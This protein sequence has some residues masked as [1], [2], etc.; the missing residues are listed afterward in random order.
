MN[1]RIEVFVE[2]ATYVVDN[3]DFENAEK[4]FRQLPGKYWK[5]GVVAIRHL[6]L[7]SKTE[8]QA[9]KTAYLLDEYLRL[10]QK[11]QWALDALRRVERN[12]YRRLGSFHG[13]ENCIVKYDIASTPEGRAYLRSRYKMFNAT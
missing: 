4:Y 1:S 6:L 2:W 11:K 3:N 9:F 13:I 7:K 10:P 5:Q 12:T 8:S